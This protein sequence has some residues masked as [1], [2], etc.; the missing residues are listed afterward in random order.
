MRMAEAMRRLELARSSTFMQAFQELRKAT[1][2]TLNDGSF[3]LVVTVAQKRVTEPVQITGELPEELRDFFK[4]C[5]SM[6]TEKRPF[7]T[8]FAAFT[9]PPVDG[10]LVGFGADDLYYVLAVWD[11]MDKATWK[12]NLNLQGEPAVIEGVLDRLLGGDLDIA[13]MTDDDIR[14]A[15]YL[16]DK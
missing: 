15:A 10:M 3:A 4:E 2:P 5:Q 14:G 16:R 9:R 13:N 6:G 12:P 11:F 8:R 7:F 1:I